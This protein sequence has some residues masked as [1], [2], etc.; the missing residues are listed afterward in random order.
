MH[1]VEDVDRFLDE[2]V[3]IS[4]A[5]QAVALQSA[6]PSLSISSAAP[7]VQAPDVN[8]REENK[9][10]DASH[11]LVNSDKM[12]HSDDSTEQVGPYFVHSYA[13]T[14]LRII[15][16]QYGDIAQDCPLSIRTPSRLLEGLCFELE[17]VLSIGLENLQH[18]HLESL[19]S[20]IGDAESEQLNVKWLRHWHPKLKRIVALHQTL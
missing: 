7:G 4:K 14:I 6:P 5:H 10:A 11:E 17:K 1:M 9:K 8:L 18:R 16:N 12:N 15:F 20:V 19:D 2:L 13:A 3:N